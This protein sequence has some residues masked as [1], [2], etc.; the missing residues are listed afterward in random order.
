MNNLYTLALH[1]VWGLIAAMFNGGIAAIVGTAGIDSAAKLDPK[2]S[3]LNFHTIM[4][5]FVSAAVWSGFWYFK[6]NPLPSHLP[7]GVSSKDA[8]IQSVLITKASVLFFACTLALAGCATADRAGQSPAVWAQIVGGT[9]NDAVATGIPAILDKNPAYA[10]VIEVVGQAIPTV[11]GG[12]DL[13]PEGIDASATSLGAKYGLSVAAQQFVART[14]K[15][16]VKDYGL[17]SGVTLVSATDPNFK[18]ILVELGQGM[19]QGVADW[20]ARQ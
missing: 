6:A 17:L 16:A 11:F 8:A 2:I 15:R 13:S 3:A 9:V 14:V 19:V 10:P 4:A 18:I 5:L 12:S 20:R 7:D 1:Y